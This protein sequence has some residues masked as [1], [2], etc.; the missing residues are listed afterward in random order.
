MWTREFF[1]TGDYNSYIKNIEKMIRNSVEYKDWVQMLRDEQ[2]A[3]KCFISGATLDECTIEIHHTPFTLFDIIDIVI[4]S[5][6]EKFCTFTIALEVMQ[7]HF[8]NFIGWYPLTSTLHEKVHNEIIKL[9]SNQLRGNFLELTNKY[10]ISKDI[11]VKVKKVFEELKW[12][13]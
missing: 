7:L 8:D 10:N 12:P 13:I 11:K 4:S 6:T 9:E 5:K 2:G 3:Y 1:S